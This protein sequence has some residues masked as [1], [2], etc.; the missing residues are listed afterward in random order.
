MRTLL[1]LLLTIFT[2]LIINAQTLEL[3]FF[4]DFEDEDGSEFYKWTTENL[5]GWHYWHI[6]ECVAEAFLRRAAACADR[7]SQRVVQPACVRGQAPARFLSRAASTSCAF[8][9]LFGPGWFQ[10]RERH[11]WPR[12]RRS[13]AANNEPCAA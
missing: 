6:V 12:A 9:G 3:P 7:C 13:G 11:A 5:E 1:T 4:E 8:T 10:G 2:V